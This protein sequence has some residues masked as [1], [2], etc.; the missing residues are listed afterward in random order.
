[1]R[2]NVYCLLP[3]VYRLLFNVYWLLSNVYWLLVIGYCLLFIVFRGK[4]KLQHHLAG[5]FC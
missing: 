4:R 5:L 2:I 3:L 1:M